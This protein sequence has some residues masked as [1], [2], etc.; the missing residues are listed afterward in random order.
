MVRR[1]L[2]FS[3]LTLAA[4]GLLACGLHVAQ[5]GSSPVS[6]PAPGTLRVASLN[7]H[8]VALNQSDGP[9]SPAGWEARRPAME[10]AIAD[11][12]P[13][14]LALQEAE[15]FPGTNRGGPNLVVEGLSETFPDYGLA[16]T[17]PAADFPPTQPIL[18][19]KNRLQ[20]TD[21]GWFF[22]SE[23]PDVIYSRTFD[24]GWAAFAS[25]AEFQPQTGPAFRVINIH[26]DYSSR[27][28]RRQSAA[29]IRDRIAPW[30]AA[31]APVIVLGDLN[32][33]QGSATLDAIEEAG[34]TF[35][36]IPGSTFHMNRGLNLIGAIDHIG[37]SPGISAT[38]PQV[39]RQ[40][41]AGPWPSDHYPLF[42]DITLPN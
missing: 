26:T 41:P 3:L 40:K 2:R 12:R 15:S 4:L 23:T 10:A 37:L 17:G 30:I 22:F 18:Y 39:Y 1:I 20:M 5:S 34:I 29:L 28:N 9:W 13:D 31:G 6:A 33:M 21:Q 7:V 38:A 14:I 32:A 25:W 27:S 19:M 16:A 42:T 11:I 35:Q 24:G 8:W 36:D